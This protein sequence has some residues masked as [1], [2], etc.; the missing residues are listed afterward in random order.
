MQLADLRQ[1][2]TDLEPV[3]SSTPLAEA[4]R[5]ITPTGLM[6][7]SI[8]ER[9]RRSCDRARIWKTP[10]MLSTLRNAK[11]GLDRAR[12]RSRGGA[13]GVFLLDRGYLPRN[14][15]MRKLFDRFLDRPDPLVAVVCSAFGVPSHDL[16]PVRLVSH[17]MRLLGVLVVQEEASQLVLV[18]YDDS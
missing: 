8:T 18:D 2:L 7:V 3:L 15:M 16:V 11:Y 14:E 1:R 13:D 10:A 12:T 6:V 17:H 9:L 4:C 5:F